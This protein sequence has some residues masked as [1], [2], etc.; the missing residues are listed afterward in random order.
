MERELKKECHIVHMSWGNVASSST[1]DDDDSD[2]S[3][4]FH[5]DDELS[6]RTQTPFTSNSVNSS[7]AGAGGSYARSPHR[8]LLNS[9]FW[10]LFQLVLNMGQIIAAITVLSLSGH[11]HPQSPLFAWLIGY[12]IGCSATLP[13][14]CWHFIYHNN[15]SS[16]QESQLHRQNSSSINIPESISYMTMSFPQAI[17]DHGQS[18]AAVF[19]FRQNLVVVG[20]RFNTFIDHFKMAVDCFFAVW[21]VV[22][23]VWIFSENSSEYSA[24]N[25][26]RLCIV[27]LALSCIGYAIP[28]VRFT[29]L[30]CVFPCI[31]S[32]LGI[33][34]DWYPTRGATS[35][36]INSLPTFKFK[37][38][39][40]TD[41]RNPEHLCQG[42]ILSP[43]DERITST[44]DQDCC[45][46]LAK[47]TSNDELRELP[48]SH[49]FHKE[50]VDKWLKI[51]ALCPLCKSEV[52]DTSSSLL[53]CIRRLCSFRRLASGVS[54]ARVAV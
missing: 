31:I 29:T 46:C 5:S 21:F 25:L 49:F 50:C 54:S 13:H 7:V 35:D 26:Y 20:T 41:T 18:F 17:E 12:A 24:P 23:N 32:V 1:Y 28:F 22:G 36:V 15:H 16:Q 38:K 40:R 42:G 10:I 45:I 14:L 52:G 4:G 19:Q 43:A 53:A 27:F 11:E 47:Y 37:S 51:N 33:R 3:D 9:G 8:S 6:T 34:D 30:C 39:R 2:N 48:C 44:D